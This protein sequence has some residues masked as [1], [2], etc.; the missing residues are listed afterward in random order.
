M[1]PL[2][3]CFICVFGQ[4]SAKLM[5]TVYDTDAS[6]WN[7]TQSCPQDIEDGTKNKQHTYID[8]IKLAANTF[9]SC[10]HSTMKERDQIIIFFFIYKRHSIAAEHLKYSSFFFSVCKGGKG[11]KLTKCG[12]SI[13]CMICIFT[14]GV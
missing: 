14:S 13:L 6:T 1:P 10:I 11:G 5:N 8:T 9:T 4:D 12:N 7:M 3:L 2:V